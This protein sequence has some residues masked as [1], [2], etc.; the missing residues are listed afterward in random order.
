MIAPRILPGGASDILLLCD[1]AS[2]AIPPGIDLGIAETLLTKHIAVDIGA[3]AVT[4]YLAKILDCRAII[5]TASRLVIDLNRPLDHP[6]LIPRESDGHVIPGNAAPDKEARI[7]TVY[8]PYHA[9]IE[10]T[11][12]QATPFLIA[13]IH[14]FTP[15]LETTGTLRPWQIGILSNTDRRAADLALAW[16]TAKG[17]KPGDNQ[18]YSGQS[19]NATLDRHG[20]GRGI[21]SLSIEL[22]NDL[23]ADDAGVGHWSQILASML[24][25]VS[26]GLASNRGFAT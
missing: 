17:L 6:G 26:N 1:H 9:A 10:T 19:L 25:H 21:A 11:V 4:E 22:R 23:I 16:L 12:E 20:E 15:R 3:E 14:S 18:P 8:R 13:E 5:A 24:T 2:N 7:A